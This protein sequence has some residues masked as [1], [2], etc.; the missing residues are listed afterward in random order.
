MRPALRSIS[1]VVLL[2]MGGPVIAGPAEDAQA[3]YDRQDYGTALHLLRPLAERGDAKSQNGLG[4]MYMNG[5]GVPQDYAEA[6]KWYRKAADQGFA[7]AQF[8]LGLIYASGEAVHCDYAQAHMWFNLAGASAAEGLASNARS[9]RDRVANMM[10]P[11][12]IA[13]EQQLAREWKP[14]QP[15]GSATIGR[16][17]NR[18]EETKRANGRTNKSFVVIEATNIP[19]V[20]NS[21]DGK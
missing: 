19:F 7:I 4:L 5:Q 2:T 10:T 16:E 15:S 8:K 12:K 11:E 6:V 1:M 9:N 14:T 20:S 13:K 3:A 21:S 17:E 18:G